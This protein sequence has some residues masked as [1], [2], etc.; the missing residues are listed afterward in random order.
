MLVLLVKGLKVELKELKET[1][2]LVEEFML[3][4]NITAAQAIYTRFPESSMLR[5]HPSPPVQNFDQLKA[6][7]A[8]LDI[9]IKCS[10]SK[11]LSDSLDN[12]TVTL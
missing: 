3:L 9:E 5:R 1:N 11:E 7:A 4:A 10:T 8:K 6:A 12:A 2:A